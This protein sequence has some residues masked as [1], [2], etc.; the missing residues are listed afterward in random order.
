MTKP[1]I[2]LADDDRD[3]LESNQFLLSDSYTVEIASSVTNAKN[4]LMNTEIDVAVIDLNFEGHAEDG[5]DLIDFIQ[6]EKSEIPFIILSSDKDTKRVVEAMRRP[7]VEFVMKDEDSEKNLRD[8]IELALANKKSNIGRGVVFQSES[9]T[10]KKLLFKLDQVLLSTSTAPIM[11]RGETGTGKEYLAKYI[12]SK[13]NKKL[14]AANM[15]SIPKETAESELFGHRKGS[16]T[17]A[18]NDKKG[19]LEE[20]HNGVFFLDEIGDC[21]EDIQTK[22]LRV[23]QEGEIRPMGD[24]VT[25]K[26]NFR[27]IA[28]THQN[29]EAMVE[30]KEFREDLQYRLSTFTFTIPPLRERPEDI[31]YFTKQFVKELKHDEYFRIDPEGLEILKDYDWPGNVRELRNVIERVIVFSK[32][33]CLDV[34]TALMALNKNVKDFQCTSGDRI[35]SKDEIATALIKVKGNRQ[36]AAVLLQVHKTT[37]HRWIKKFDLS[38]LVPVVSGRPRLDLH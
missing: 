30:T 22:L 37:L 6:D 12:A 28:A 7:H 20:S 15:A 5:I 8:A 26:I 36:N 11:I 16:F 35:Y 10:I 29:L 19:L 14:V 4:I 3:I 31:V 1:T 13:L 18:I 25:K 38:D 2:L 21:S 23:I 32:R 9:P 17:G 34:E 24:V 33:R 27:F